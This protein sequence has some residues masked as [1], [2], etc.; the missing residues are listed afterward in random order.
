[1]V[2][3]SS[4][5]PGAPITRCG[6]PAKP[7]LPN[8]GTLPLTSPVSRPL[9]TAGA[10][11]MH[12]RRVRRMLLLCSGIA[13]AVSVGWGLFFALIGHN[14]FVVG[15]DAVTAA[16]GALTARLTWRGRTQAA[17]R[18]L[19]ATMYAVLCVNA[20][21]LDIPTPEVPRSAH[22][23]LLALGLVAGLLMREERPWLR[24]G[25]PLVCFATYVVFAALPMGWVTPYVLSE[26]VRTSGVWVNSALAMLAVYLVLHVIQNDV[27]ER[28]GLEQELRDALVRGEL[29]LHYQPQVAQGAQGDPAERIVGAEALVRWQHPLRGMV[30]PGEFIPLAERTGLMVPLGDW[31]LK[32]ACQQL[33][34]WQLR[35]ETA[36]LTVA[37]NVSALQ[38]AQA[39][40]V[41]KVLACVEHA[42]IAPSRLKLE[43]TESMLARDLE[44]TIAKMASLRARGIGFSLDDFGTGYSSLSYL[45]RLPLDQ[46]KIDQSF[47]ASMLNSQKEAAIVQA[48]ISLGAGLGIDL[49][50]EGVET[51]EQ[52][53]FLREL[54]C[55]RYQGY[56]FSRPV[57]GSAF[58]ALLSPA[59]EAQAA[60]RV[61]A[62]SA[63]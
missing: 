46:I 9:A 4:R 58:E 51:P 26:G 49:I 50:A 34:V 35:P 2:E 45:R 61:G 31:V 21:L 54:G 24:H 28:N 36:G 14:W 38:L 17:S 20:G 48:L 56:L 55:T 59:G 40:F 37:V 13:V 42:G 19:V 44:D 60:A 41:A 47:V 5:P 18:L 11:T 23:F 43:L 39:D 25:V 57:T 22:S 52:R 63:A 29:L 7:A 32:T 53:R 30:S 8:P 12:E 15:L 3:R 62:G 10:T 27:A 1:M 33:A 6:G 16:L